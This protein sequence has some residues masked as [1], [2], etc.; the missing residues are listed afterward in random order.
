MS[1]DI[2]KL[3]EQTKNRRLQQ[4]TT[5]Q[6]TKVQAMGGKPKKGGP[7]ILSRV[8]DV[9]SRPI[10]GVSEGIARASEHA[11]PKNPRKGKNAG[12]DILKGI[13][14]GL[15]GKNKTYMDEALLRAAEADPTSLLSK[16]IRENQGNIRTIGGLVGSVALD[17]TTYTGVGVV[18]SVGKGAAAAKGL[19][20]GKEAVETADNVRRVVEAAETA[21]QARLA[22]GT[23]K[24]GQTATDVTKIADRVADRVIKSE[25]RT[26]RKEG[27]ALAKAKELEILA[28]NPGKVQLKFAGKVVGESEKLYKGTANLSKVVGSTAAGAKLS[29]AFRT[30]HKFPEKTLQLKREAELRGVAHA[31]TQI[32]E[33]RDFFKDVAKDDKILISHTIEKGPDAVTSMVAARPELAPHFDKAIKLQREMGELEVKHG[34]FRAP[35]NKDPKD[36]LL[37]NYVYHS[38]QGGTKK[39]QQQFKKMRRSAVGPESPDFTKLRQVKTLA[40][41]KE[42]GLKPLE[43][44]DDILTKRIGKHHAAMARSKYVDAVVKEYGVDIGSKWAQQMARE[45]KKTGTV[46]PYRAVNS[47]YAH[48]GMVLPD[49]IAQSVEVLEKMHT[50]DELYRSFL[51]VFDAAQ[52]HWKFGATSLNPGHHIRNL[53]GDGWNGFLDGVSDPRHYEN[54]RKVIFGKDDNFKIT[55][56][57]KA[58]TRPKLM[59]LFVNSGTKPGFASTDLVEDLGRISKIKKPFN[60]VAEKREEYMRMAHFI[61]ALKEEAPKFKNLDEAASAAG[62]RVRK[63]KIDYGDVTDFERHVM[64]RAIPF[65]TWSRKN[66]PLQIEALA[67]RPGRVAVI[68]KGQRAI[69]NLL[70]TVGEPG[71]LDSVP[72]WMKEMA[73]IRLRGEGEGKNAI[74][75]LPSLPFQDIG[76]YTEG[77]QQGILQSIMSQITP[78]ARVPFEMATGKQVFSGANTPGNAELLAG[79]APIPRQLFNIATGKQNPLSL[80]TLNWATGLG[81]QEVTPGA[82]A[83]ELRRQEDQT[84]A[85][86]RALRDKAK[87]K[88]MGG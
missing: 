67:M 69:E 51:R 62:A 18:R 9:L 68:P 2:S 24:P 54:A 45:A 37:D 76:K 78:A 85:A 31:D 25:L 57:G 20:A 40:E 19:K 73:P 32:R 56:N 28:A 6:R 65:Y 23:L 8:F 27:E 52:N 14:G 87:K 44:I 72:K 30:T 29:E 63:W 74:Y 16:P 49:H 79:Q 66:I 80:K 43:N 58:I 38:Y 10:Y 88:A 83:G 47:K 84:Q 42:F 4:H 71:D 5:A 59:E 60:T 34:V 7:S 61:H 1:T 70:G 17:P 64:K 81:I 75:W 36:F 12:T 22:K 48:K 11:G 33:I 86:I 53:I 35:K 21:K 41:A 77:G 39:A 50:D 26:I 82:K 55:V 46:A 15:A 13:V 3:I